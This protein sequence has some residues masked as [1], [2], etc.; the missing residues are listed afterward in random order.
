MQP[1]HLAT[2]VSI[3]TEDQ[4]PITSMNRNA[5]NKHES[6]KSSSLIEIQRPGEWIFSDMQITSSYVVNK[7]IEGILKRELKSQLSVDKPKTVRTVL[8]IATIHKEA[9]LEIRTPCPI[10]IPT[11]QQLTEKDSPIATPNNDH[12]Q[13]LPIERSNPSQLR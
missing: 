4:G 7:F 1:Q 13:S 12:N 2:S 5:K 9:F 6:S 11:T 8:E 10:P 3:H